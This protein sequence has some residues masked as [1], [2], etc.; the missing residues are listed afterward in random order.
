MTSAE[1]VG[2]ASLAISQGV[3]AFL[4][5]MPKLSEIR[6]ADPKNDPGMVGDVRM[7]EVAATAVCVGVGAIV[8]SLTGNP[9]PAFVAVVVALTLICIYESALASD[10]AWEPKRVERYVDA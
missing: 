7:G 4:S 6:K 1:M 8:S 5:F 3:T 9:V 10:R 2:P